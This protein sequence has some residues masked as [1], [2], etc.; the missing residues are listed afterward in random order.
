MIQNNPSTDKET[1]KD[2]IIYS[3][4]ANCGDFQVAHKELWTKIKGFEE[5][6]YKSAVCTDTNVQKK[7]VLAGYNLYVESIPFV[8]HISHP[9]RSVWKNN[10]ANANLTIEANFKSTSNKDRWGFSDR[11][12]IMKNY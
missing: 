8:Y 2:H 5:D 11:G 10:N 7:A 3:R 4:I 12:F 6:M 1:L 9:E